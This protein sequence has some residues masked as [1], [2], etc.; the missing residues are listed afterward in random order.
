MAGEGS[1]VYTSEKGQERVR[2]AGRRTLPISEMGYLNHVFC[3]MPWHVAYVPSKKWS[4]TR[5]S[6]RAHEFTK[7]L[8]WQR[9]RKVRRLLFHR[10]ANTKH[11]MYIPFLTILL[12]LGFVS[13]WNTSQKGEEGDSHI[14][15]MWF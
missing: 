11:L 8:A 15:C 1:R 13:F 2:K 10:I 3:L 4:H 6:G 14:F 7:I 9:N 12:Q 5:P